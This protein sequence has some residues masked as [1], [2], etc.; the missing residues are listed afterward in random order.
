[1][2]DH[3]FASLESFQQAFTSGLSGLLQKGELGPFILVCA[4][5]SFDKRV[6]AATA[7]ELAALYQ[8][9]SA[10]Y[11]DALSTGKPIQAVDEDLHPLSAV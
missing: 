1:M 5:A 7:K 8:S 6:E 10:E 11:V 3:P 9:L 4:N 2:S